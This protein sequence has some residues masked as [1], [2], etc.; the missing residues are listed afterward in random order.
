MYFVHLTLI[1]HLHLKKL[2]AQKAQISISKSVIFQKKKT[3]FEN[4]CFALVVTVTGG[5]VKGVQYFEDV[6]NTRYEVFDL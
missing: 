3:S 2:F 5:F 1:F 6:H 4:S